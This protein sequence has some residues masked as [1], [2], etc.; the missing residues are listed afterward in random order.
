MPSNGANGTV[1]ISKPMYIGLVGPLPPPHGGMANQTRQLSRLLR[2]AGVKVEV[3]QCNR[4]YQPDWIGNIRGVRAFFRLVPYVSKLWAT[5]RQVQLFHVMANSSLSWHLFAAPAIWV[6]WLRGVPTIIN[7][8]GGEAGEFFERSFRW[9]QPSLRHAALLVVPSG[10]LDQIFRAYGCEPRIIPNIIDL[11][12]F[13]SSDRDMAHWL[14][15]SRDAPHL[16]VT[17]NLERVYDIDTAIYAFRIVAETYPSARLT[18]AGEGPERG[19]LE[20]LVADLCLSE[21]VRFA[22]RLRNDQVALLYQHADLMLNPSLVDNMPISILEALASR[23]PVVSTN[24]GGI[25]FLVEH[26]RTA[27]LVEPG[28]ATAMGG[29]SVRLL[30]D[31]S[32]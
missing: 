25:P 4:A 29:Q 30:Q 31:Q 32:L 2:R 22:G 19:R 14:S 1:E 5:A 16:V 10:F 18:I 20:T 24:V 12:A 13:S 3:V 8:R 28:Q 7:Y 15:G 6:A 17:R 11:N 27:L 23:V 9:V 26:E 21:S